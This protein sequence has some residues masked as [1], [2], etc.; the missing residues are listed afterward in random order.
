M[1]DTIINIIKSPYL[2][3][4]LLLFVGI[5]YLF[6]S[7]FNHSFKK[8]LKLLGITIIISGFLF[9]ILRLFIP[10]LIILFFEEYADMINILIPRIFRT[11]TTIG[12]IYI[13]IGVLALFLYY[14]V[15]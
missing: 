2:W 12:I 4:I 7:L 13:L 10:N 1:N 14:K 5:M 11:I 3:L 6:L 8:P 15:E 9:I